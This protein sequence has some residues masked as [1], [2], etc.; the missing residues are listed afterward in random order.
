[1]RSVLRAGC[2]R[3]DHRRGQLN[4]C[5]YEDVHA[6]SN[7]V[8]S[9]FYATSDEGCGYAGS[10]EVVRAS[11]EGRGGAFPYGDGEVSVAR[12]SPGAANQMRVVIQALQKGGPGA[13]Y[14]DRTGFCRFG[15]AAA[16]GVS[17]G[18]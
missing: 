14:R 7:V 15:R 17:F 9:E 1:V 18:G 4:N 8:E 3:R 16:R 5:W 12:A 6:Q 11:L 2:R 10:G 13:A